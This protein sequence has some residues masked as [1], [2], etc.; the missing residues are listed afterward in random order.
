MRREKLKKKNLDLLASLF[1]PKKQERRIRYPVGNNSSSGIGTSSSSVASAAESDAEWAPPSPWQERSS[2]SSTSMTSTSAA[3]AAARGR[4]ATKQQQQMQQQQRPLGPSPP[5][6]IEE[7]E[8]EEEEEEKLLFPPPPS[9]LSNKKQ[10]DA[11]VQKMPAPTL[12]PSTPA[13]LLRLA[14]SKEALAA[15]AA[16]DALLSR[17]YAVL[18]G[19]PW[20][21]PRTLFF[22]ASPQQREEEKGGGPMSSTAGEGGEEE[23]AAAPPPGLAFSMRV[24]RAS[25]ATTGELSKLLGLGRR[26]PGGRSA[27]APLI[28]A[29]SLA[30]G[31]VAFEREAD[32]AAFAE[33]LGSGFSNGSSASEIGA[34]SS[35]ELF[36]ATGDASGVVV[37]VRRPR[38]EDEEEAGDE[39][40]GGG[41][42]KR[43]RRRLRQRDDDSE[44]RRGVAP[45]LGPLPDPSALAAALK[46][47]KQGEMDP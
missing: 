42:G 47:G 33:R 36:R 41:E 24:R 2:S 32:A 4:R 11:N 17:S 35:H 26:R 18:D 39:Q 44:S 29:S 22:L 23:E 6:S 13:E 27:R 12:L 15:A 19:C 25:T 21:A 46:A 8:E 40:E 10:T 31:V 9:S 45:L 7:Q 1:Q 28:E 43:R 37:L 20:P 34:V 16:D 30:D 38:E 14:R 5:P 3:V